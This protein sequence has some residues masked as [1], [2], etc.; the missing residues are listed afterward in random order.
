[1]ANNYTEFSLVV[2]NL[3]KDEKDWIEKFHKIW[4]KDFCEFIEKFPVN[5][6]FHYGF[7]DEIRGNTWHIYAMESGS[8]EDVCDVLEEFLKNNRS[9]KYIAFTWA[10]TCSKPRPGEFGGGAAFVSAIGSDIMTTY[11]LII[12]MRKQWEN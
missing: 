4:N 6:D 7:H 8:P 10:D 12:K 3:T 2:E 1:M 5:P 9:N 11:D